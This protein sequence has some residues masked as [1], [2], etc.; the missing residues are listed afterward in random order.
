MR[1]RDRVYIPNVPELK[2]II[3]EEDH[4]NGLSIH[5]GAVKMDQDLKK[6]FWCPGMREGS[7]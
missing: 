2:K 5:P 3:L 1:F 4:R 6:L 7:S